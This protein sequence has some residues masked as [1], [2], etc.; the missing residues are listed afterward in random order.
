[1]TSAVAPISLAGS[2]LCETRHV[3]AFFNKGVEEYRT[4]L[5]FIRDG[6]TSGDKAVHVLNPDQHRD[7]HHDDAVIFTYLGDFGGDAVIN[8]MLVEESP[9]RRLDT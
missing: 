3:C 8:I 6:L 1:M 9:L 7:H 5:P 4:L 2:Q